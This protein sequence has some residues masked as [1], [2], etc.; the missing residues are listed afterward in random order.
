MLIYIVILKR[1]PFIYTEA[2]FYM[3]LLDEKKKIAFY[4]LKNLNA[5]I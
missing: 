2:I 4:S 1:L 3:I 5:R